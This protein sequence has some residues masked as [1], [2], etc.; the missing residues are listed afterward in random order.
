MPS[1]A[2]IRDLMRDALDRIEKPFTEDVIDDAFFVIE[3]T[4]ELRARYDALCASHRQVVVHTWGGWWIG[5]TVERRGLR[6]VKAQKS[7][8]IGQY[9][10][11][12]QPVAPRAKALQVQLEA[13]G[14]RV[15]EHYRDH[16]N[17]MPEKEKI[18]TM[19]DE[20]TA[21]VMEGIPVEEAF[22]FAINSLSGK[23][24]W[25]Q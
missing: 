21:M 17:E 13:A 11:L 25:G 14:Q 12:D 7:K 15:F 1:T 10:K 5:R 19:R 16:K 20:I 4:P 3:T 2:P 8:L 23:A 24:T 6:E 9:S 22:Q 18:A